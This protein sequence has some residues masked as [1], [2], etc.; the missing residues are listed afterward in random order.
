MPKSLWRLTA[1]LAIT[2]ILILAGVLVSQAVIGRKPGLTAS[3]VFAQ[4]GLP[5][6]KGATWVYAYIPY[7]PAAAD[8][9]QIVTATYRLTETV[10]DTESASPYFVAHVQGTRSLV[11]AQPGWSGMTSDEPNEYW[12]LVRG[13]Q[14]YQ[15]FQKLDWASVQTDTLTL[16]YNLPLALNESWCPS[17]VVKGEPVQDCTAAGRRIVLDQG[18]YTTLAGR[19][20]NCYQI[21]EQYNSGGVEW[22]FCKGVGVVAEAYDHAGTRFGFTQELVSYKP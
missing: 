6:A 19:F 15:S 1:I 11:Q 2:A 8:P 13:Q 17:S 12:Y 3:E 9:T 7:E 20:D 16:A 14:I 21:V 4:T 22:W 18:E 5:V 10:V